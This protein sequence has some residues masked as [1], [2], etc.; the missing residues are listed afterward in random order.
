MVAASQNCNRKLGA[1]TSAIVPRCPPYRSVPSWP[2]RVPSA[3]LEAMQ[4][5]LITILGL[6]ALIAPAAAQPPP[7]TA[8]ATPPPPGGI[9]QEPDGRVAVSPSVCATLGQARPAAPTVPSANYQP[10]VDVEGNAVAPADLPGS[11]SAINSAP[12]AIELDSRLASRFK[13]PPSV[14]GKAILGYVELRGNDAYFN[15]VP[16]SGD[17]TAALRAACA[18]AGRR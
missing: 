15:G 16:L 17:Q 12:L 10:G 13:L 6:A 14:S 2:V 9:V 5:G 1:S 3:K 11:S 7:G 8:P 4:F 18:Q